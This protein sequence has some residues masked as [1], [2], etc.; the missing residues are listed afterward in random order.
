MREMGVEKNS[1]RRS[2]HCGR[3]E[4]NTLFFNMVHRLSSCV[5]FSLETTSMSH[6]QKMNAHHGKILV[7]WERNQKK[8]PHLVDICIRMRLSWI[9]DK[10]HHFDTETV[11]M[12][13]TSIRSSSP[14]ILAHRCTCGRKRW[15]TIN[16]RVSYKFRTAL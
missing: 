4:I 2:N 13:C 14:W 8:I 5:H 16:H 11:N 15:K 10:C 7:W 6:Q 3:M 9:G 12:E 1:K